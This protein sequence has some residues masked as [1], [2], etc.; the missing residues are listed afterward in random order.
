MSKVTLRTTVSGSGAITISLAG[1][2]QGAFSAG[3]LSTTGG[4]NITQA[5]A[6]SGNLTLSG[7][8]ASGS[9]TIGLG[10]GTGS[11]QVAASSIVTTGGGFSLTGDQYSDVTLNNVTASASITVNMAG[12]GS[13]TASSLN[14]AGAL[15]IT[16]ALGSGETAVLQ[17]ISGAAVSIT[18][19]AGSGHLSATTIDSA[20]FTFDASASTESGN[21]D[22]AARISTCSSSLKSFLK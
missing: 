9:I 10:T 20:A 5:Q 16:K 2:D 12:S 7:V 8:S 15:S 18:L 22:L 13:I 17:E 11:G 3:I 6:A 14:T 1:K 19:G 4:V 21:E